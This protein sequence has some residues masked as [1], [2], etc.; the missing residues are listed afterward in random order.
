MKGY[1]MNISTMH[2]H[3]M[4][5]SVHPG[6]KI[7]LDDLYDQYGK[8][9]EIK[10]GEEFIAWLSSVKLKNSTKWKMVLDTELDSGENDKVTDIGGVISK[11]AVDYVAPMVSTKMEVKEV[12]TLS[13]RK[14]RE[15]LPKITDLTLLKYAFQEANQLAGKDSLCNMLRKRIKEVELGR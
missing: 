8:K 6:Q 7:S 13:V 3:A 9:H 5:R 1:V 4:K 11:G 10:R 2:L 14:A 15:I 12:V